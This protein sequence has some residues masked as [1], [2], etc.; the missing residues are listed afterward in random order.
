MTFVES[1]NV[2]NNVNNKKI[3]FSADDHALVKL[4][5]QQKGYDAKKFIVKFPSKS[6]TLSGL[7]KLLRKI[8]ISRFG[9]NLTKAAVTIVCVARFN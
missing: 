1:I 7:N 8:N 6:W 4:L 9:G 5:R 3:V 2:K